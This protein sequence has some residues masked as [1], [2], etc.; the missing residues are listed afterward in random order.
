MKET[1]EQLQRQYDLDLQGKIKFKQLCKKFNLKCEETMDRYAD[2]DFLLFFKDKKYIIEVKNRD[3]KYADYD[4][5]MFED[6]KY[7]KILKDIE[8]EQVDGAYYISFIGNLA[9]IFF[10]PSIMPY[11]KHKINAN[12]KTFIN[13]EKKEKEV[14][15][16]PKNDL[17]KIEI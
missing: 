9:Y 16:L 4:S 2:Y 5:I 3:S 15:F 10:V 14:Y 7:Q 8:K 13:D 12:K 1:Q 17:K 6:E 11:P